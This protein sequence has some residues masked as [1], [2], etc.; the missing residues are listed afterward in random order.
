[1][2]TKRHTSCGS[3]FAP[4][5]PRQAVLSSPRRREPLETFQQRCADANHEDPQEFCV[6]AILRRFRSDKFGYDSALLRGTYIYH[7]SLFLNTIKINESTYKHIPF[8]HSNLSLGRQQSVLSRSIIRPLVLNCPTHVGSL[9]QSAWKY[10]DILPKWPTNVW[11]ICQ[12]GTCHNCLVCIRFQFL[13]VYL[14]G[15]FQ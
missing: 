6:P 11:L 3:G 13:C 4:G 15:L 7:R 2:R 14:S 12:R 10:R 1:M 8:K 9:C 5:A